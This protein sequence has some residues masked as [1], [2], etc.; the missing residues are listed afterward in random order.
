MKLVGPRAIGLALDLARMPALATSDT[1]PA[2]PADILELMRVAA[3]SPQACRAAEAATG[4]P[5]QILTEAARFYLQQVLFRRN[6]DCYRV[7]GLQ[8]GA[9]RELARRHMHLLLQWL[10]PDRNSGWDGVYAERV[11]KAWHEVSSSN[12]FA[13]TARPIHH[14]NRLTPRSNGAARVMGPVRLAWIRRPPEELGSTKRS[15]RSTMALRAMTVAAGLAIILL[16]LAAPALGDDQSLVAAAPSL[17]MAAGPDAT[18]PNH[19]AVK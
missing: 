18:L 14:R 10:H 12:G 5:V 3:A 4:V 15:S 16:L 13:P 1:L 11:L 17:G 7:L 9:S 2:I 6:A 19:C 8:P